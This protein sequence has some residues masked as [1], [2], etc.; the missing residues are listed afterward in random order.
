MSNRKVDFGTVLIELN[1]EPLRIGYDMRTLLMVQFVL[2][3]VLADRVDTMT[4]IVQA[5]NKKMPIAT[6]WDVVSV[7]VLSAFDNEKDLVPSE[8]F[9][10]LD[11][12]RRFNRKGKLL[13]TDSQAKELE[14]LVNKR[15]PGSLIAPQCEILLRGEEFKTTLED[16]GPE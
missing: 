7:A 2:Q 4:E 3:E 16:N 13:V 8:K 14:P 10:R 1:G 6:L 12:A 5:I 9:K 11:L 15:W